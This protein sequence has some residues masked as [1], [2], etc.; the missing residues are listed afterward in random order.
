[1]AFEAKTD[2]KTGDPLPAD[3][4]TRLEQGI[5]DAHTAAA[6]KADKSHKHGSGDLTDATDIGKAIIAAADAAAA[7]EAIGAGTSNLKIGTAATDAK[8]GDYTPA[9]GD[10]R[11]KPAIP[12]ETAAGTYEQLV[13]G[14]DTTVRAFSAKDIHSFVDAR[15]NALRPEDPAGA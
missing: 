12:E 14:T 7:R 10:V 1:M 4:V 9:W 6:G 13:A 15:I 5:A 11:N 2:W 3:D 8:S